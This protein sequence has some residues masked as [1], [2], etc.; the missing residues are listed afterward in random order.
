MQDISLVISRLEGV[1]RRP[2]RFFHGKF[3][4]RFRRQPLKNK[5]AFRVRDGSQ[6]FSGYFLDHIPWFIVYIYQQKRNPHLRPGNGLVR[7]VHHPAGQVRR[8]AQGDSGFQI[9]PPN[10]I[11]P[12]DTET[13]LLRQNHGLIG[14]TVF[15]LD[16][17]KR[18]GPV[19]AGDGFFGLFHFKGIGIFINQDYTIQF[20]L[21]PSQRLALPIHHLARAA[22]L[23]RLSR[24][25]L[26]RFL[27]LGQRHTAG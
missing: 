19:V 14:L 25:F 27:C 5:T 24:V 12:A 4:S 23:G 1:D 21:R 7:L 9:I 20:H 26:G 11:G 15:L 2:A 8:L 6:Q 3:R 16:S 22:D 18:K 13:I 17:L 10:P